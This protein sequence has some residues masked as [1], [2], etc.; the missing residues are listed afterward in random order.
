M[1]P[2]ILVIH[3]KVYLF[4]FFWHV[5][6]LLLWEGFSESLSATESLS[7]QVFNL[8]WTLGKRTSNSPNIRSCWAGGGGSLDSFWSYCELPY[9]IIEGHFLKITLFLL[10]GFRSLD[11]PEHNPWKK[12][13]W[14]ALCSATCNDGTLVKLLQLWASTHLSVKWRE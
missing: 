8:N 11:G 13:L 10:M 12:L 14:F 6:V 9:R 4:R 7:Q 1:F 3:L 5:E 2:M